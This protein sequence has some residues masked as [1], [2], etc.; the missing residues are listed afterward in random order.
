MAALRK[1][2][3]LKVKVVADSGKETDFALS[4][5]GFPGALDKTAALLK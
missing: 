4:L 1:G 5:K 2:T 3:S